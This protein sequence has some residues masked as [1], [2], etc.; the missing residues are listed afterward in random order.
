MDEEI[1][2]EDQVRPPVFVVYITLELRVWPMITPLS[3]EDQMAATKAAFT[4][5]GYLRQDPGFITPV[6]EPVGWE[7]EGVLE[8]WAEGWEVGWVLG[9]RVG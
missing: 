1:T 9:C 8:G 2:L 7:V 6:G 4:P 5:V 3:G